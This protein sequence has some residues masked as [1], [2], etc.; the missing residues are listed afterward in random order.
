MRSLRPEDGIADQ[1]HRRQGPSNDK[2]YKKKKK[3]RLIAGSETSV[4][5]RHDVERWNGGQDGVA[6]RRRVRGGCGA[7]TNAP[8]VV[9]ATGG[10]DDRHAPE[11]CGR[12]DVRPCGREV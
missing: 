4:F 5:R 10:V 11:V 3:T 9:R 2:H 12:S 8:E 7:G 6:W 1:E